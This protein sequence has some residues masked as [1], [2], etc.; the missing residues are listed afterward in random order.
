MQVGEVRGKPIHGAK[1]PTDGTV[2]SLAFKFVDKT[3]QTT[4]VVSSMRLRGEAASIGASFKVRMFSSEYPPCWGGVGKHVQNLCRRIVPIVDLSLVTATYEKPIERF[5][6]KN[7]AKI[8]V[9]SFPLL[10]CQYL[11]G[12]WH[13]KY[14]STDLTHI[15]VPH[16]FLSKGCGKIVST[17]HV[18]W[19]EYSR[20]LEHQ[21]PL[22]MFDLQFPA[23]N[24]RLASAERR[25]A[26]KSEAVI[27]VSQSVRDELIRH[28]GVE[29]EKIRVIHNGVAADQYRPSLERMNT[30]LYVGRQT[31]HKG[32]PYLL[33]AFATFAKNHPEYQLVLVGERLEGGIDPFLIRYAERLGITRKVRFTG[34]LPEPQLRTIMGRAR[35]LVLPSLAESFGMTVLEAMASETPV[36]ATNVGG[37]PEVVT[38][39]RNGLLVPPADSHAIASSLSRIASDAEFSAKLV[40]EARRTAREFSWDRVAQKNIQVYREVCS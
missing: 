28:Y 38:N 13:Q 24:R 35:C 30:I 20:A 4:P 22:S 18:V 26:R 12:L 17:F 8:R 37:I 40:Q 27:A 10:L 5:Y 34:R 14:G 9:K 33:K 7:L 16:A 1:L 23:L 15:H 21:R 3:F 6:V 31:A 32:L 19:S 11:V 25:L 29:E 2:R 39:A 36:V